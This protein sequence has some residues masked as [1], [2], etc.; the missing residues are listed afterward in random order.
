MDGG[1][2]SSCS[3]FCHAGRIFPKGHISPITQARFNQPVLLSD[4][5]YPFRR[6]LFLGQADDAVLHSWPVLITFPW[7]IQVKWRSSR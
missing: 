6:G 2:N 7:R 1:Q 3:A 4:L 5:H